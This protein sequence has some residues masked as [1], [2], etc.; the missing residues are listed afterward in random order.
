MTLVLDNVSTTAVWVV[1]GSWL[2]LGAFMAVQAIV[3]RAHRARFALFAA[4]ILLR[5]GIDSAH[6]AMP[7]ELYEL[8]RLAWIGA[9]PAAVLAL[10]DRPRLH[11][12]A[13]AIVT[14]T[15]AAAV[16]GIDDPALASSAAFPVGF[17]ISALALGE[18]WRTSR[19]YA[20]C[21]LASTLA[22][23]ALTCALYFV[24]M[25]TGDRRIMTLGYANMALL[26]ALAV[27]FG[28]I[29]LPREI[30]GRAPVQVATPQ[31]AA[32]FTAF[33][34][35]EALAVAGLLLWFSWPPLLFAGANGAI[36]LA[37]LLL[38]FH[39]RHRLV[40]YADDVTLLLDQRTASLRETQGELARRIDLQDQ[41]LAGQRRDLQVQGEV[42]VRQRRLEL[43]AQTAGQAAH[44]IQNLV[45]PVLSEI[46]ILRAQASDHPGVRAAA[47][48]VRTRIE[49]LLELNGELLALARRG[50]LDLHPVSLRELAR[51]ALEAFPG[52]PV[53]LREGDSPW[54]QGSWSQL[55]R[56][57]GNL[58]RNA[59][60]ATPRSDERV[61][62]EVGSARV[63]TQRRCH[64]GFLAPGRY[65]VLAVRDSGPG[66]PAQ[67][68]ERV[69]EPFFSTKT[70]SEHSGTGLGLAI[71]AAVAEDQRGVLDLETGSSGTAF[72]LW[73][74]EIEAPAPSADE[75]LR[76]KGETLLLADDDPAIQ[77]PYE[78]ILEAAGYEVIVAENG[79]V[80]LEILEGGPV[81]ILL[82]DLKMPRRN[83]LDVFF[84][85]L[86]LHSRARAVIHTSYVTGEEADQ[87]RALGVAEILVKP[88]GRGELLRAI[89]EALARPLAR[90]AGSAIDPPP[91][92]VRTALP[93]QHPGTDAAGPG[94]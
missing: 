62:V 9:F 25:R 86:H 69:F 16:W 50:R 7:V 28:W 32:H 93:A 10:L 31:A 30:R 72:T 23:M 89:R 12:I 90:L 54:V 45:S 63:E 2:L 87:L 15:V 4:A 17:G 83:G 20:S 39:H 71:V 36:L 27:L 51:Q 18:R 59:L 35:A 42:I 58:V 56:A 79:E 5:A 82:L 14:W 6:G 21:V 22:A 78:R 61:F 41:L 53:V 73:F 38:F 77:R 75:D 80:A 29:H 49:H 3:D 85:A 74:P 46:A 84:G 60:E 40:I 57:L 19:G 34:L 64:L 13:A 91:G 11:S 76:G 81:D 44:D 88:A 47:D 37:T 94:R 1:L 55:S 66:I 67:I 43:A 52:S 26:N 92:P 70:A 68:R 33:V 8:L 65:A 48:R 24:V